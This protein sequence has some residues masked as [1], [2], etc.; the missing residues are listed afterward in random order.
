[1][2][3]STLHLNVFGRVNTVL[4][5]KDSQCIYQLSRLSTLSH[6]S[7][8][9]SRGGRR[10]PEQGG[11]RT[12]V[13]KIKKRFCTPF[14][15]FAVIMFRLLC[16]MHSL[17]F[18]LWGLGYTVI[19]ALVTPIRHKQKNAENIENSRYIF[20]NPEYSHKKTIPTSHLIAVIFFRLYPFM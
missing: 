15:S 17:S 12:A 10:E 20:Q 9:W 16:V 5:D 14:F 8:P 3:N 19:P 2:L 4:I 13:I 7:L 11:K 18:V 6:W 1:M